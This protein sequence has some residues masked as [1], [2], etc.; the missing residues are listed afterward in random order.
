MAPTLRGDHCQCPTC[1][2]YFNSTYAFDKHR[3]GEYAARRC[4]SRDEM[5]AKGMAVS[6]TGF[7]V[8][9]AKTDSS[10]PGMRS[11]L[12]IEGGAIHA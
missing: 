4:M 3:T 12:D 2:E 8:S 7:L 11:S 1:G 6:S 10:A 5:M 9:H